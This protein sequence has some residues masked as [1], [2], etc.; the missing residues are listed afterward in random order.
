[1][2]QPCCAGRV[3][4]GHL[5]ALVRPHDR[6][7]VDELPRSEIEQLVDAGLLTGVF[8]TDEAGVLIFLL[9]PSGGGTQ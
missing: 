3:P 4:Q 1:V 7:I 6:E 9:D 5:V 8:V 2:S